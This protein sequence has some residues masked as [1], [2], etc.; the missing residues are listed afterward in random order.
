MTETY[1]GPRAH[2]S[3]PS[4]VLPTNACDCHSHIFGA[5]DK[6]P[7]QKNRSVTPTEASVEMYLAML[8]TLGLQRMV[9]VQPSVYGTDNAC[10]GDAIAFLG[11]HRCRGVAVVDDNVS[12]AELQAL[13]DGGFRGTRFNT[14]VKGGVSMDRLQTLAEKIEPFGWHIQ[15]YHDGARLPEIEDVLERLP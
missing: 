12:K 9:I 10:T 6:Y 8:G 15:I 13:H 1:Q 2:T 3:P 11:Q 5:A 14:M 7:F 4:F